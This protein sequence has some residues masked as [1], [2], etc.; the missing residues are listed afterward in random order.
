MQI[1]Q[2]E[3]EIEENGTAQSYEG[4]EIHELTYD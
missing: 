3:E 2:M 1:R 4:M